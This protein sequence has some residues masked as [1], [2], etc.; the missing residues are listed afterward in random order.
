MYPICFPSGDQVKFVVPL[1]FG[2]S[3]ACG[4]P[5]RVEITK[6]LIPHPPPP[7]QLGFPGSAALA[8][9]GIQVYARYE[10]SGEPA[11]R[12]KNLIPHPPPAAQLGFPGSAALASFG[13]QVYARYE[14][15]GEP[16]R[17]PRNP[18]SSVVTV[19]GTP[20]PTGAA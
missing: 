6:N 15:S 19:R 14:P 5:P 16:A 2:R 18:P 12:T 20:G 8:S 9:F 13:I 10:P 7:A 4:L 1:Y 3:R 11:R 17:R